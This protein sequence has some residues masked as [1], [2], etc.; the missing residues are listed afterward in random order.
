MS[1]YENLYVVT[2]VGNETTVLSIESEATDDVVK[3]RCERSDT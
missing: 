3:I 2:K 1:D